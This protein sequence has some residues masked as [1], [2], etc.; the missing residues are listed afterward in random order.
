MSSHY[1]FLGGATRAPYVASKWAIIGFTKT[2]AIELG[3]FGIR[4]NAICP[5]GVEGERLE[6][7]MRSEAE[8]K[9]ITCDELREQWAELG[10]TEVDVAR[11]I[12]ERTLAASEER[13]RDGWTAE[14]S[15]DQVQ[16][17]AEICGATE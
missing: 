3:P 13:A 8:E 7:V 1:G 17:L 14:L 11:E 12:V 6:R 16:A 10:Q 9:G 5:G 15:P 2:L 4:A